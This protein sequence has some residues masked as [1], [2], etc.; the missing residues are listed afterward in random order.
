MEKG[1]ATR[2]FQIKGD[3]SGRSPRNL[4]AVFNLIKTQ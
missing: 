4:D 1:E 2:L 3:K